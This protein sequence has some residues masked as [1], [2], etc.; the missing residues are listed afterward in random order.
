MISSL[1]TDLSIQ[2]CPNGMYVPVEVQGS[3][4]ADCTS[5]TP[6][7]L[8][9]YTTCG[10]TQDGTGGLLDEYVLVAGAT[11][12]ASDQVPFWRALMPPS[13]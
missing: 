7:S 9:S 6:S 4:V 2:Q 10:I 5:H 8:E 11:P 1:Q 3:G 13:A 12:I